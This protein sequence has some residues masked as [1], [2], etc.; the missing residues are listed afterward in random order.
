MRKAQSL[1]RVSRTP[2]AEAAPPPAAIDS[3]TVRRPKCDLPFFTAQPSRNCLA[4]PWTGR[5][6]CGHGF[7]GSAVTAAERL[8]AVRLG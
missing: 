2:F 3:A 4:P 8:V 6:D 7:R 5:R 1:Q